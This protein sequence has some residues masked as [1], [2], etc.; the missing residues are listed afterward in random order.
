ME[1]PSRTE[2]RKLKV[3]DLRQK[4][5]TLSLPQGGKLCGP[6]SQVGKVLLFNA[7]LYFEQGLKKL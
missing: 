2:L 7:L 1:V 4:L 3:V 5:S 6:S